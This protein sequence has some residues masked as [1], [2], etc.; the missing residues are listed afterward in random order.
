MTSEIRLRGVSE[1]DL[2]IFFEQ[3]CDPD[4]CKMAA[5]AARDRDAFMA[6]WAKILAD[7]T[8]AVRS[9]IL[10]GH[11]AGNMVSW[12]Q[13]GKRLI[14][15]WIGKNY[16]GQGVA[17]RALA[18]FLAVVTARPLYAYVAKHNLAS[19][20]VLEKC[21]FTICIEEMESSDA[22]SDGVEEFVFKSSTNE[23][24]KAPGG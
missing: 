11:V 8:V 2:P 7:K 17:T 16:W 20:R 18:E 5:F 13:D 23:T 1:G 6:H 4:A 12:Q 24:C 14:G 15:Y 21:G 22:P 3:Q 19:I 10:D 9:I